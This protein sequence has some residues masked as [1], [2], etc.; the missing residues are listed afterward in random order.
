VPDSV[1]AVREVR[2]VVSIGAG[3]IGVLGVVSL[4]QALVL[5]VRRRG[6]E[7]AVLRAL[8]LRPGQTARVVLAQAL[9]L[10]TVAVGIGIPLG[11]ALGRGVWLAI[12]R[13]SYFVARVDVSAIGLALVALGVGALAGIVSFWPGH[14]AARLRLAAM[15]HDE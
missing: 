4:A 6:H 12:A 15:L 1:A 3:L 9:T 2:P 5:G 8:G 14:R 10:G 11:L 13:P 7:L